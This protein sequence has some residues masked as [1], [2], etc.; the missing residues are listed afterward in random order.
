[1]ADT[2]NMNLPLLASNQA[3][4]HV[5][6][7]EA[8]ARLDAL[9]QLVIQSL[10]VG[11]PPTAPNEGEVYAVPP[12]AVNAWNGQ[13]GK[14]AMV[15]GG[16]WVFVPPQQGWIAWVA[17]E[18]Y[19]AV[20]DGTQWAAPGLKSAGGA[21]TVQSILERDVIISAGASVTTGLIVPQ[22]ASVLGV[23]GRILT[24]F[25]GTATSWRLGVAGADNRYASGMGLDA[26]S[27]LVGMSGAPQTYYSDTS[28]VVTAE[29]GEFTGGQIRL[30][31]HYIQLT[32]PS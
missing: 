10:G 2:V 8:L 13:A 17:D 32:P 16:G 12:G 9:G 26:G 28:L 22:Y 19:I 3:Q 15:I 4:K 30:A 11:V 21:Q 14:L 23:T 7:N 25:T 29:G 31:L 27:W 20:F 1:M 24:A 5:T 18:A 6:V